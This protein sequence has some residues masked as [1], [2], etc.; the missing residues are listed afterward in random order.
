MV[1]GEAGSKHLLGSPICR[2]VI[3]CLGAEPKPTHHSQRIGI[4]W[5]EAGSPRKDQDLVGARLSDHGEL[6][7]CPAGLGQRKPKGGSEIAIPPAEHELSGLAE[8]GGSAENR[9]GTAQ[10]RDPFEL[11]GRAGQD[12]LG[13]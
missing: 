1:V 5:H 8:A 3:P 7:E 13:P 6:G 11:S 2:A 10:P 9:D 12:G 4:E